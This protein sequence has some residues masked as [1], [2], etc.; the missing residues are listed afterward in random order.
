MNE[1]K[2]PTGSAIWLLKG[3]IDME[4]EVDVGVAILAASRG[5]KVISGT[6]KWYRR[7]HGADFEKC[8]NSELWPRY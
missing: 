2:G 1:S 4:I 3:D 8:S 7:R 5:F 6:V